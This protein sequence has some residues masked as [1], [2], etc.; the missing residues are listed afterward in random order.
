MTYYSKP[1]CTEICIRCTHKRPP[2]RLIIYVS[3][4]AEDDFRF[5]WVKILNIKNGS[6]WNGSCQIPIVYLQL[7]LLGKLKL[8]CSFPDDS[9]SPAQIHIDG[10]NVK[11][12]V[13]HYA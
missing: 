1:G 12:V 5:R 6:G 3:Q 8:S 13:L 2:T 4:L 10:P 9:S 11:Q 7:Y